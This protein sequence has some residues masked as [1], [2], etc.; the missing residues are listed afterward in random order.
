MLCVILTPWSI[1]LSKASKNGISNRFSFPS[2]K[3]SSWRS[4]VTKLKYLL[5]KKQNPVSSQYSL[6]ITKCY[7]KDQ[8]KEKIIVAVLK[9]EENNSDSMQL[10]KLKSTIW[11]NTAEECSH[12][13]HLTKS[14]KTRVYPSLLGQ[15]YTFR[16]WF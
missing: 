16:R 14:I 6:W 8:E 3:Y 9:T 13:I 12:S 7:A 11:N 10:L 15:S 5:E 2:L 4:E 1:S